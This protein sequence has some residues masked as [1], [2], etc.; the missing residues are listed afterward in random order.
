MPIR[1][2]NDLPATG[3]LQQ[4]N[5]FVMTQDRATTQDT[6]DPAVGQYAAAGPSGADAYQHP[7][8]QKCVGGSSVVLL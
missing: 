1:I 5:I 6:A 2:P 4:E 3:V 7:P 8:V